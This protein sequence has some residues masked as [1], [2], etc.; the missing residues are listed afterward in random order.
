VF[1]REAEDPAEIVRKLTCLNNIFKELKMLKD[2]D[3]TFQ[4]LRALSGI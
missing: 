4:E 2:A 1:E 3:V